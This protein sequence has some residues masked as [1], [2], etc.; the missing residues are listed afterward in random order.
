MRISS[1]SITKSIRNKSFDN[2][3]IVSSDYIFSNNGMLKR[4]RNKNSYMDNFY[5]NIIYFYIFR[6]INPLLFII[7]LVYLKF[8]KKYING[9]S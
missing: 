2:R 4:K 7:N 3:S 9:L 1:K 8:S 5:L 6:C